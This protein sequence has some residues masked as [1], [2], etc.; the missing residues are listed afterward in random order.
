MTLRN[1]DTE[2]WINNDKRLLLEYQC[3]KV[4]ADFYFKIIMDIMEAQEG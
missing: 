3:E 1:H 4:S 2:L